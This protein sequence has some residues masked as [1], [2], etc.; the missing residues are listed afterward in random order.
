MEETKT[1]TGKVRYLV[2]TWVPEELLEGWNTWHN[3]EHVPEV[4]EL[5]QIRRASKYRVTDSSF[6]DSWQPQYVTIY[7][8]D[9]MADL[10]PIWPGAGRIR[11][12]YAERYGKWARSRGWSSMKRCG[13]TPSSRSRA[14]APC[15]IA[16]TVRRTVPA[17]AP[18]ETGAR[19]NLSMPA[20]YR[21]DILDT[22]PQP[23]AAT[24]ARFIEQRDPASQTP[25]CSPS[26][27]CCSSTWPLLHPANPSAAARFLRSTQRCSPLRRP[28]LGHWAA[29]LRVGLAGVGQAAPPRNSFSPIY[30]RLCTPL[31]LCRR[32]ALCCTASRVGEASK[33]ALH[34]L[35]DALV[36]YRN[37]WAHGA[38]AGA[39]AALVPLLQAALEEVLVALSLTATPLEYLEGISLLRGGRRAVECAAV[40]GRPSTAA[41]PSRRIRGHRAIHRPGAALLAPSRERPWD[42]ARA[43]HWR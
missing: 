6:P 9:S 42:P 17:G 31:R 2:Y 39:Y 32:L 28:S 14:G 35:F 36:A 13:L 15:P 18:V 25:S 23:L 27:R 30:L 43:A 26:S 20:T 38:G 33:V 16:M 4:V 3:E 19:K 41:A 34:Q 21:Q 1:E 8:L 7:E 5:P 24:Y 10:K 37:E 11:A 22:Y 40:D 12:D 29:L